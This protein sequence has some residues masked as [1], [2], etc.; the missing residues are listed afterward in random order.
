MKCKLKVK[1]KLKEFFPPRLAIC[2]T[3]CLREVHKQPTNS[4]TT[5]FH[6]WRKVET[7]LYKYS[8][9]GGQA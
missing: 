4:Q 5:Q 2:P 8:G 1:C 6:V 9:G 3:V 7:H